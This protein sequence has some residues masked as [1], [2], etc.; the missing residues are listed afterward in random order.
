VEWRC[1][2]IPSDENPAGVNGTGVCDETLE[3]LFDKQLGQADF[4]ERQA[5]FYQITKYLF[6]NVYWLGLWEDPDLFGFS[7]RMLN[8]KISGATPFFNVFE[9]DLAQ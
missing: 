7:D 2:E 1:A 3:A 9:W 8:V 4:A 6:E 5:T